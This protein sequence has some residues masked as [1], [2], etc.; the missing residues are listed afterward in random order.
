MSSVPRHVLTVWLSVAAAAVA[1]AAGAAPPADPA[2]QQRVARERDLFV[3]V[4]TRDDS[5]VTDLRPQDFVV[6]EDGVRREVLAVRRATGP[7]T[8]AL[9]ID[10]SA[11]AAPYVSD[12]RRALKAFVERLDPNS[13]IAVTTVADRPTIVQDYTQDRKAVLAAVDRIFSLPDSGSTFL[14]G[15]RELSKGLA[16]RDFER[17][18]IVAVST[19]G[20][21]VSDRHFS[22][23]LPAVR[24]SGASLEVLVIT[25]PGGED[26]RDEGA[27]NRAFAVDQGS[28]DT[29][30]GR[31]E[32]LTS[33]SLGAAM[34]NVA[35]Q[36]NNQYRVTYAR[37]DSLVPPEKIEVSVSRPGLTA[38]G[39]PARTP[40]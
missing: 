39:T 28:R 12:I 24:A 36:L 18:A 16:G 1:G 26:L 14:E 3:T 40:R 37:P 29:G 6:R 5:P 31:M 30:G 20:P 34:E 4:T 25:Q 22:Q 10:N 7:V 35:A 32:L 13:P 19:Q 21:E 23:V 2:A 33:M 15:L 27:R 8:V 38:R 9:M 17:A 11:A